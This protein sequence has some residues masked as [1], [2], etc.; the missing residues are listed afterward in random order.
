MLIRHGETPF[1]VEKRFS[2]VGDPALTPNGVAQAEALARRL[3]GEQVD[4]IVSSPL[5]RARQTAE[6]IAARTGLTVEVEEDLRET[7]FGA[8]EGL[9]FAEVRQGW[10]DLL[11]AWLR[12]PEAAPPGGE[13]FAAPARRAERAR[14]RIIEAHPGRRVAVVSHVTPIKLLVRAAL[15]APFDAIHRMHLDLACL[16][17]IDHYADGP[18]VVR[19]LND[20][21]H[22]R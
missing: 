2:G 9:T 18:A 3:A 21:G 19:L 8:W 5:K 1:S 17:V 13:S 7:D 14:R 22:L 20:T 16:S 10:P 12:D 4:A 15:N 11:T 6:A